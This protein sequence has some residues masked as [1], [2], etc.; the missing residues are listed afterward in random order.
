MPIS[1]K[2]KKHSDVVDI[3]TTVTTNGIS[4]NDKTQITYDKAIAITLA[5]LRGGSNIDFGG[6]SAIVDC[7]NALQEVQ[8]MHNIFEK[9]IKAIRCDYTNISNEVDDAFDTLENSMSDNISDFIGATNN[10]INEN[11]TNDY[12]SEK[13]GHNEYGIK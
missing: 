3:V 5:M 10:F 2:I 8:S 12:D 9:A 7:K 4:M 6:Q 1:Y 11:S 13:F